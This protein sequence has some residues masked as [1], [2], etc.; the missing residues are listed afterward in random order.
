[1]LICCCL[2][3]RLWVLSSAAV[4]S[5]NSWSPHWRN[6]RKSCGRCRASTHRPTTTWRRPATSASNW[7][8]AKKR[9]RSVS[10]I[11]LTWAEFP[12]TTVAIVTWFYT[13]SPPGKIISGLKN[14][15]ETVYC[16]LLR[17]VRTLSVWVPTALHPFFSIIPLHRALKN[18]KC[19]IIQWCIN[20]GMHNVVILSFKCKHQN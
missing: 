18:I 1:M 11:T 10:V 5:S 17:D 14:W 7:T 3:V 4:P 16:L 6:R 9:Y 19:N 12:K 8:I 20:K 13:L 2:S 15:W